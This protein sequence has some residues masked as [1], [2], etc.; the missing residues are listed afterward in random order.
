MPWSPITKFPTIIDNLRKTK[1]YSKE[2]TITILEN[3]VILVLGVT[4]PETISRMIK[5][6]VR[7]G[8]IKEAESANVFCLCNGKAYEF[9]DKEEEKIDNIIEGE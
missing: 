2:V 8:Y 4:K 3:E 6:M 5:L 7:F 9:E 1:G